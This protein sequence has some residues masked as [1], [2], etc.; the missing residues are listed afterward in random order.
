MGAS[1][2]P[3]KGMALYGQT[4]GSEKRLLLT[5]YIFTC[6]NAL[7]LSLL[8]VPFF[9]RTGHWH[10]SQIFGL[11]IA[12]KPLQIATWSLLPAYRNLATQSSTLYR[13]LFPKKGVPTPHLFKYARCEAVSSATLATAGLHVVTFVSFSV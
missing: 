5:G 13:H 8:T 4:V 6:T 10:L 2:S 9:H 11:Q 12:T 3:Q 1:T 7:T